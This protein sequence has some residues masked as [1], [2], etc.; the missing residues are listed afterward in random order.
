MGRPLSLLPVVIVAWMYVAELLILLL[1]G[2]PGDDIL[3]PS[4]VC[5]LLH[6]SLE[7]PN[8]PTVLVIDAEK[9][10]SG[11]EECGRVEGDG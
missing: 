3:S 6:F 9:F 7:K 2:L 10:W 5:S 4:K 8:R 11:F 1:Q